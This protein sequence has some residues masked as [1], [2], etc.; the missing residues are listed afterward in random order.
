MARPVVSVADHFEAFE[1][2]K[3]VVNQT[4][5]QLNENLVIG[6]SYHTVGQR[7]KALKGSF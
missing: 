3:T 7:K 2:F 4:A 1:T 6:H 5:E